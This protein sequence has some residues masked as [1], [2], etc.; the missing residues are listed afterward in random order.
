MLRLEEG[1]LT[2][3]SIQLE[4]LDLCLQ[5]WQLIWYYIQ[6]SPDPT[7]I[8]VDSVQKKLRDLE[9]QM[10]IQRRPAGSAEQKV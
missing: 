10:V 9:Q 6:K 2:P 1:T 3:I 8:E 7:I 4:K 5:M